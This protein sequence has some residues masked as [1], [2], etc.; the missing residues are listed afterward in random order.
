MEAITK[1]GSLSQTLVHCGPKSLSS[2][3]PVRCLRFSKN[4]FPKKLVVTRARTSINSDHEAANRPLFQFP[5]SLLD[6]RFLS[7]SANQSP[8]RDIEALKAKVSEKLVCMDVKERIHLIHLLVSLGVAYHFEKQ[9]EEFLKVDFEN[10]E[11]MNL[12]EEDMYSISVIFR[13]FRLYRHKLSSGEKP[14]F[15]RH[16]KSLTKQWASRGNTW[17]YFVGGSNEEHLSGHIKNVLY[18]S[19]QENAEVVMSREYIQF[20]EQETHHDE[21]LLKFAKINFKFMQLHYVQELQ[22]IVKWWKELDLESKIPNYYRV[23]AVECLYWAMAVYMEPQYSVARIILSKSLVLWTIIDDLYD[24][25]CTLPEAIAFTENMERWETD[26][27]DMPDHMK[28]LLRSLIDLMEDFKGE[29]RSEGRLYSVEYGIDEWKRL[30]RADLTI[31]KWARTGYIPNYDEYMEVGIVTGG[32]DVTVAFAFIG[33][34]EAGKEAFDWIRS[35]PK[36]IQTIDLK[37]RLRDDVATYKD[38]MARGEIPTGINCYMKQYK[39]T[40]EEAFLE[41]HR[42]IKHTSKLVNEEY[43]KTTVPLK[44]VRIAFNVGRVIDTNYKH[45]DGLTYTGI[46]GGQITSLFLDLITI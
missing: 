9:I 7:I 41:F 20:Y 18:L 21:T 39:V 19:Q 15:V 25:Y 16:K 38:E 40:E 27:I 37:S 46:V 34:G 14:Y 4:P 5:P 11:D 26:A 32:V 3:I 10:V 24:A 13:V 31:S 42:R 6:D 35:R 12:G 45:G 2:F 28:V 23:R 29:V 44:L 17:N 8:W 1:N 22:T 30:F 33:M 36:F 43:F